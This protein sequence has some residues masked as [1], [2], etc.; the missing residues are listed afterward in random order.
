MLTQE[1]KDKIDEIAKNNPKLVSVGL[2]QKVSG[3]KV[4]G[5]SAIV[6][7]VLEKKPI[8]DLS[9]EELL[10]SA[11]V[12]GSQTIKLD[13]VQQTQP[14]LFTTCEACGGWSGA[15]SGEFTN[16]QYTRPLRPGVTMASGN[17]WPS[18]GTFGTIVK[19][20]ETGALLGLT[21][22]HVSIKDASYTNNRLI[23]TT[24]APIENDYDP[25]NFIYQGTEG[26]A[27]I[28]PANQIGRSVRYAPTSTTL[29]NQ[30]DA[31][32]FSIE[33]IGD[34]DSNTSWLPIGLESQMSSNP[35]F[36]STQELN[37]MDLSN[38]DLYSSGRTSGARG[39]GICGHLRVN[40]VGV[41][42]NLYATIQEITTTY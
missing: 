21:N 38:P 26:G 19:D 11:V 12:A 14:V 7:G 6:C 4:T 20:V 31:A 29:P 5:E 25:T 34:I 9:P 32:L 39:K 28:T 37:G 24:G 8:E 35:P 1:I 33:Q 36:A 27:Y 17:K 42:L 10:P 15:S 16:R 40:Q 18:I 41:S 2:G 13:V 30:I 22:N 3:G 23:G